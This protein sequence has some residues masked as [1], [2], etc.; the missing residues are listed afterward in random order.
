MTARPITLLLVSIATVLPLFGQQPVPTT[1]EQIVVSAT[2]LP[3]D[4]LDLPADTTVITGAELRARGAQTLSD[5]LATA[6]GVE[7]FDGSDQGSGLPNVALCGLK[8]FDAY[9]V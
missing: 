7:A 1:S 3:E 2:K 6:E 9:L 8:E 5:A 4:E